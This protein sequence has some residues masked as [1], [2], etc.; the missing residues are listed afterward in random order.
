MMTS[1]SKMIYSD[2]AIA[3]SLAGKLRDANPDDKYDIFK[4]A[5]GWQIV[6]ITKLPDFMPPAVPLPVA[7]SLATTTA[8]SWASGEV[9]IIQAKFARETAKWFYFTEGVGPMNVKEVHKSFIV[10]FEFNDD[11]QMTFKVPLKTA[12]KK[13]LVAA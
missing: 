11:N 12:I 4:L 3:S 9:A 7:K 10:A 8:P 1:T 2:H 6:R 13:G 5:I